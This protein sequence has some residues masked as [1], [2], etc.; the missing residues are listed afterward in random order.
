MGSAGDL[1]RRIILDLQKGKTE[2]FD[3][4]VNSL[5]DPKTSSGT[6]KNYLKGLKDCVTL[7]NKTNESSLLTAI[8]KMKWLNQSEGVIKAYHDLLI[9]LMSAN[10][11]YVN[12]SLNMLVRYF[13][14]D[15]SEVELQDGIYNVDDETQKKH[16]DMFKH[17]HTILEETSKIVPLTPVLLMPILERCYPFHLI[18][19][20]IQSCYV[21][22]LLQITRYIPTIRQQILD[23]IVNKIMKLDVLSPRDKLG[24]LD[25]SDEEEELFETFF[26]HFEFC[27]WAYDNARSHSG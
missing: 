2:E 17:I 3:L 26:L 27:L 11:H 24:E 1:I 12:V 22:N 6:V 18:D 20:Y 4:F 5:I 23:L 14:P 10:T 21:T 13:L 9:N 7:F 19:V 16:E 25:E 8:M 15:M